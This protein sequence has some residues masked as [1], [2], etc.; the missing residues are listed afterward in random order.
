MTTDQM[1]ATLG[2]IVMAAL[3]F[4]GLAIIDRLSRSGR[5][6]L[7]A[8]DELKKYGL[9]VDNLHVVHALEPEVMYWMVNRGLKASPHPKHEHLRVIWL[10]NGTGV[11][12]HAIDVDRI[13]KQIESRARAEHDDQTHAS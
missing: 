2:I 12:A 4:A 10:D 6:E 11:V 1:I 9:I 13:E 5:S 7:N 8:V 3:C